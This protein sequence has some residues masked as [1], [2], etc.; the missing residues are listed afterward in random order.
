MTPENN[1]GIPPQPE[2][3]WA[4]ITSRHHD[5]LLECL[6]VAARHH[7]RPCTQD[8]LVAGLPLEDHLLTPSLFA[9]AASRAGL[10]SKIVQRPLAELDDSFLPVVLLLNERKACLL[11]SW[12]AARDKALVVMPELGE[13]AMEMPREVLMARYSGVAILVRPRFRFGLAQ[14]GL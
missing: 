11:M 6:L 9:R 8:A 3:A 5:P 13:A 2:S 14:L 1:P 10:T 12:N 7:E 4:S